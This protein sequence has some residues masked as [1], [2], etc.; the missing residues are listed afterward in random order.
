MFCEKSA[1]IDLVDICRIKL[2]LF[3]I[4]FTE[5]MVILSRLLAYRDIYNGL[6]FDEKSISQR[7]VSFQGNLKYCP[8]LIFPHNVYSTRIVCTLHSYILVYVEGVNKAY[9]KRPRDNAYSGPSFCV[10]LLRGSLWN[11]LYDNG[12]LCRSVRNNKQDPG[13]IISVMPSLPHFVPEVKKVLLTW[14]KKS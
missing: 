11:L 7:S 6:V 8:N 14:C 5:L 9:G 1:R 3:G 4:L 2:G 10:K 13:D 12:K